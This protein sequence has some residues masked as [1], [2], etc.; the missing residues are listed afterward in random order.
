MASSRVA[1][2]L[3]GG[4]CRKLARAPPAR[5]ARAKSL[6]VT[7][8]EIANTD[9]K[10]SLLVTAV[11]VIASARLTAS[12]E[13]HPRSFIAELIVHKQPMD[14]TLSWQHS[15]IS[16]MTYKPSK[17]GQTDLVFGL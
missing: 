11:R 5:A 1:R 2:L 7:S 6:D 16:T 17:V 4:G 12:F 10:C 9:R 8:R 14:F 15:Y 13:T 3:I